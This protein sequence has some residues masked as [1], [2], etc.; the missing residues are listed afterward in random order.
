MHWILL[1]GVSWHFVVGAV[2]DWEHL[3]A[4][5]D[6]HHT[7][8]ANTDLLNKALNEMHSGDTLYV[9]NKTFWLAGGVQAVGLV[10]ATIKIDGTLRFFPGREGWPTRDR[11]C[12]TNPLQPDTGKT[13]VQEAFFIANSSGLSLTSSGTGTLDGNG[14]SW[15]GYINYLLHGEN[16]PRLLS[17]VNSTDVLVEHWRFVNSAYWT[18]T[19]FDVLRMEIR[20]CDI[21]N[22]V[23]HASTHGI[24]NLGAFNTDGFDVAGRNIYIHHCN[25]WNQDDCFTI[26]P[27]DSIYGFNSKCTENI[28]VE[29][30]NASGL[31]LTVG[32]VRPTAGHNC[33]RNVTFRKAFMYHTFKGIYIKSQNTPDTHATGE[34]TNLLYEDVVMDAPSQ[35]PIWIG[36]AQE[37]DSYHACSLFWP[38]LP[39]QKCPPP[40]AGMQWTNITLRNIKISS[41]SQSPGVIYGNPDRPMS[42]V[43]FDKV[44][45]TNPGMSPW[46]KDFYHCEGVRGTTLHGTSPKPPCFSG[47]QIAHETFVI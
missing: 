42:N 37:A 5:P 9:S 31:G 7:G 10:S 26:Q 6:D 2:I 23:N 28:L 17:I 46:G 13:C 29:H 38:Q 27:L 47:N 18:F 4:V 12:G 21:D 33:V 24:V 35:V 36:P 34:I 25:V 3:G 1:W 14:H 40:H 19:A 39:F 30:I 45:V 20:Y 11:G 43:V 16:R 22:R 15:W 41:P 32:A 44:V 8:Q